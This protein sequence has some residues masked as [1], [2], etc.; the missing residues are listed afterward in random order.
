[1]EELKD[2]FYDCKAIGKKFTRQEWYDY[3]DKHRNDDLNIVASYLGFDWNINDVCINPN[4]KCKYR[5]KSGRYGYE[6]R[7]AQCPCGAWVAGVSY[8]IGDGGGSCGCWFVTDPAD[9]YPTEKAAINDKLNA[10]KKRLGHERK[11]DTEVKEMLSAI[12]ADLERYNIRQL[13]LF[14]IY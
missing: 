8:S 1:M 10:V 3:W 2:I 9:G 4:V 14:G 5:D 12:N 6:I 11:N 7:T 13:D